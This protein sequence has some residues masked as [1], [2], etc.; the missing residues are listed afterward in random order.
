MIFSRASQVLK[1]WVVTP[2]G[3]RH[4]N[5]HEKSDITIFANL[6]SKLKV[7][8]HCSESIS[9]TAQCMMICVV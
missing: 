7:S 3:S 8:L 2:R 9:S 6:T 1:L 5:W 4:K